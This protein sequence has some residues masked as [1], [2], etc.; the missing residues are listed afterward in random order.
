MHGR[1][2]GVF[3]M[4]GLELSTAARLG[5]NPVVVVLDNR[6]Y[7]T[8]RQIADGPFNDVHEWS[9]E[10]MPDL[11]GAGRGFVARTPV[12]SRT[13]LRQALAASDAFCIINV[14]LDPYDK[15]PALARLGE[16]LAKRV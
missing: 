15:S 13:A 14:L 1:G 6:G 11:L 4:A 9:Y 12:E 8:E 7:S 2:D 16:K 10:N 5:L 3:Q